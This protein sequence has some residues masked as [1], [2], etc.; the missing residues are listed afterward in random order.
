MNPVLRQTR[1]V[2][3]SDTHNSS[4]FNGSYRLPPGDGE[5]EVSSLCT[6]ADTVRAVLI[7]AGDLTNQGTFTELQKTL[8]WIEQ[9]DYETKIV[10]A[11]KAPGI[12]YTDQI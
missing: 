4:P 6:L 11:G 9:A 2:C 1:I 10:I 12:S 8:D 5:F 7:H 3:V